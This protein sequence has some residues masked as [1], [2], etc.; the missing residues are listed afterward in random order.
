M[1]K[2]ERGGKDNRRSTCWNRIASS[3]ICSIMVPNNNG[4]FEHS[5]FNGSYSYHSVSSYTNKN[6]GKVNAKIK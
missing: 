3:D 5:V 2:N 6:G 1:R 4:F